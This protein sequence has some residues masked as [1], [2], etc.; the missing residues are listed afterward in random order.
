[1]QPR[2]PQLPKLER[3]CAYFDPQ[4]NVLV[5]NSHQTTVVYRYRRK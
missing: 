5:L 2:G 4:R 3:V 1:M